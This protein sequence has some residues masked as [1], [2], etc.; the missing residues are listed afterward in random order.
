VALHSL[1]SLQ[2]SAFWRHQLIA[3]RQEPFGDDVQARSRHQMM[4][5]GDAAGDRVLDWNHAE[6]DVAC[7]ERREAILEG[8]TRDRLVVR[9]GVAAGKMRVRPRLAL[10]NDL[11]LGHVLPHTLILGA[12]E[13]SEPAFPE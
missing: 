3:D 6:I 7:D 10:E 11:F 2:G 13:V 1:D 9:I 12:S 8:R 4:D 5:I